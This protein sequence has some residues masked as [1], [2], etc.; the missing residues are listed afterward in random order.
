MRFEP[1][2]AIFDVGSSTAAPDEVSVGGNEVEP[3]TWV[4]RIP[5]SID[6]FRIKQIIKGA[7]G[8]S[9]GILCP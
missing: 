8:G 1:V 6:S 7:A 2:F 4:F 9:S 3:S 5:Y